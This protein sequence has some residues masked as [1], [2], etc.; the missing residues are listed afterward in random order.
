MSGFMPTLYAC[1]MADYDGSD[2]ML[3]Y[4]RIVNPRLRHPLV[5]TL[6]DIKEANRCLDMSD[7]AAGIF[8]TKSWLSK[9]GPAPLL[10]VGNSHCIHLYRDLTT[11]ELPRFQ[12]K[13]LRDTNFV[14]LG[15]AKWWTIEDNLNGEG[16]S[17]EKLA[18][19]GDQWSKFVDD[20][21]AVAYMI[22]VCGTNDADDWNAHLASLKAKHQN[23]L[24]YVRAANRDK[25]EWLDSL[26]P[27]IES[28]VNNWLSKVQNVKLCYIPIFPR[29]YWD[30]MA[31]D[32]A[33]ELDNRVVNGI[34]KNLE[35]KVKYLKIRSLFE[36][37]RRTQNKHGNLDNVVA[38]FMKEDSIHLNAKGHAILVRDISIPIMDNWGNSLEELQA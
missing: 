33:R 31:R 21:P 29:P 32:F 10:F 11:G 5:C 7:R 18:E 6:D 8:S 20:S 9:Y 37:P 14:A 34:E 3:I 30:R 23:P 38:G 16:L 1:S 15:G 24:D 12:S 19:H 26:Y 13:I 35:K 36:N 22:M 28:A 2:L 4:Q 25:K 17:A 27:V